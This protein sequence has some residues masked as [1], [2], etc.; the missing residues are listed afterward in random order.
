MSEIGK[1]SKSLALKNSTECKG[2][3][4]KK[5]NSLGSSV[6][7]WRIIMLLSKN[8]AHFFKKA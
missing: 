4:S 5:Y 8:Y 6:A 1:K 2:E 3:K 7:V